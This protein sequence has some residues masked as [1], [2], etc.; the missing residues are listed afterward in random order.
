[1]SEARNAILARIRAARRADPAQAQRERDGI[2]AVIAARA[3][4]PQPALPGDPLERFRA[5]ALALASTVAEVTTLDGVPAATRDYLERNALG[6]DLVCWPEFGPLDWAG[7]GLRAEVRPALAADRVGLTGCLCALAETGTLVLAS[8][9]GTP[10][11][12]SLL[13]ETHIAIV[14]R[15]RIVP[16]M[17]QAFEL[18]REQRG[19]LPRAL[20]FVSGP[21]RT[22]DIEQTVTLGAHGPYRVHLIVVHAAGG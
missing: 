6:R 14:Y 16:R 3:A 18:V 5:Q 15:A 22:A 7:A 19:H 2:E 8:S 1:M 9:A 4:G 21:S 12:T 11:A 17:E 13:P 20:N 10:A